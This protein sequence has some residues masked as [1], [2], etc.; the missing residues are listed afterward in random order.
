[1]NLAVTVETV[2]A[3]QVLVGGGS[4]TGQTLAAVGLAGMEG[5]S[6]ALLAQCGPAGGQQGFMDRPMRLVAQGA[7][8]GNRWVLP[9]ERPTLVGVAAEAVVVEGDL[10]QQR[11]ARAPVGVMAIGTIRLTLGDGVARGQLKLRLHLG[12]A[13][14]ADFLGILLAEDH[15]LA[16]VGVVATV[17][18]QV[19]LMV[20]TADPQQL[21][22][23]VVAAQ[24]TGVAHL[25]V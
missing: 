1:M 19:F 17:A 15:I 23:R 11:L 10:P 20:L 14:Q 4:A 3:Y 18:A 5:R 2:L 24:A 16:L 6:V 13:V 22:T 21:V 25:G 12:M 9:E 8:F 7:I